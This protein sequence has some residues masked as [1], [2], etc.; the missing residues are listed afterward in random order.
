MDFQ[1]FKNSEQSLK[2][3][4]EIEG[5]NFFQ[6]LRH[7]N[8]RV[9]EDKIKK[10]ISVGSMCGGVQDELFGEIKYMKKTIT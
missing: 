2:K 6:I 3:E 4:V 7:E 5:E 1:T 10:S 9:D 8:E